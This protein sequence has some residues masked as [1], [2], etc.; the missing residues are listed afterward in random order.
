MVLTSAE[1][2]HVFESGKNRR[3]HRKKADIQAIVLFTGVIFDDR[4]QGDNLYC[5]L[6]IYGTTPREGG[7]H[8]KN[9]AMRLL[10]NRVYTFKTFSGC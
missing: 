10:P 9:T 3:F 5:H 4:Q 1:I 8:D 7:K 2:N 6:Q